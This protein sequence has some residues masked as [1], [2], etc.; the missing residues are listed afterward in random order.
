C[1]NTATC[2]QTV[3]VRDITIPSITC[4]PDRTVPAGVAWS[5]DD[6][7]ATDT[8]GAVTVLVINTVTNTTDSNTLIATRTWQATDACGNT[9]TCQQAITVLVGQPPVITSQP[10]SQTFPCGSVATLSVTATGT[11]PLAYQWRRNETNLAGATSSSLTFS[12]LDFTNAGPYQV[13]VSNS[14][15]TAT[16]STAMLNVVPAPDSTAPTVITIIPV[17]A[18]TNVAINQAITATFSE[19]M[20]PATIGTTSFLLTG[21]GETAVAGNVEYD[22]ASKAAAFAPAADLAPLTTYT[23]RISTAAKDLA[24]NALAADLVW[25][26]TTGVVPDTT[27]PS[28]SATVPANLAT[29][30]AIGGQLAGTF[31]EP[32]N[33]ATID[34]ATLTLK[35]GTI[36]VA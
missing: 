14:A 23:A 17:D 4:K 32:M 16:S 26:F 7:V 22:A 12:S 25:T 10:Q 20:D 8:C 19:A 21:P 34:S 35:Q 5:F 36:P 31:S 9:A 11:G 18:N 1:G 3:S 6:P 29:G 27:A 30:V 33:P 15:G 24:G 13:V 2:V 28:V